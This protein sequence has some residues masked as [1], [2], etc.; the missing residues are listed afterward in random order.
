MKFI[1][2]LC[3]VTLPSGMGKTQFNQKLCGVLDIPQIEFNWEF[4]MQNL[5]TVCPS[6]SS[7]R[8]LFLASCQYLPPHCQEQASGGGGE[9]GG[10][11]TP[12]LLRGRK[13]GNY[14]V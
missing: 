6:A 7:S 3:E 4:V 13:L 14:Q 11:G 10:R 9:G 12:L 8:A 2:D 5:T 1:F